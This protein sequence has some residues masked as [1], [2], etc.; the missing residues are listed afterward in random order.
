MKSETA[1]KSMLRRGV[2]P[3]CNLKAR[4][5]LRLGRNLS[6]HQDSDRTRSYRR[7][8]VVTR[9]KHRQF[10]LSPPPKWSRQLHTGAQA[11]LPMSLGGPVALAVVVAYV[12]AHLSRPLQPHGGHDQARRQLD[13]R[14]SL[15]ISARM[16]LGMMGDKSTSSTAISSR[17]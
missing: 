5:I 3:L 15:L 1:W 14:L 9:D 2:R 16:D 10:S 8:E 13:G 11:L 17:Y 12:Y 7:Q 6:S 4:A